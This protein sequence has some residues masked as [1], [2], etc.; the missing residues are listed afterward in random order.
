LES[1]GTTSKSYYMGPKGFNLDASY[2][3]GV[4]WTN[5]LTVTGEDAWTASFETRTWSFSAQQV[6]QHYTS[7][8]TMALE[9]ATE[10]EFAPFFVWDGGLVLS[11]AAEYH[12]M[13]MGGGGL[14]LE[15][16]AE[17]WHGEKEIFFAGDMKMQSIAMAG[18]YHLGC[19]MGGSMVLY[20]VDMVG[21]HETFVGGSGEFTLQTPGFY[22]IMM[23]DTDL[24]GSMYL[25]QLKVEGELTLV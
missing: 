22:G 17:Y 1:V 20:N 15:G 25:D 2:D 5:L 16:A 21:A 12:A 14:V 10:V 9:G 3:G 6:L 7:I 24:F 4:S 11:G 8:S 13:V 23:V 18:A 19:E